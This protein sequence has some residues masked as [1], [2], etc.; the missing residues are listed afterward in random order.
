MKN[1]FLGLVLFGALGMGGAA[2][3]S[4]RQAQLEEC[5]DRVRNIHRALTVHAEETG[6]YLESV[7]TLKTPE[8][9]CTRDPNAPFQVHV[10]GR[11]ITVQCSGE[12]PG[13]G[14]GYPRYDIKNGLQLKDVVTL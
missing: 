10:E 4:H 1:S 5:G 8:K 7:A 9:S 3:H 11:K 6:D 14:E 12:H 13:A 2:W